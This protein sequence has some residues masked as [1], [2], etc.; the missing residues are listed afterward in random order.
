[1]NSGEKLNNNLKICGECSEWLELFKPCTSKALWGP[2]LIFVTMTLFSSSILYF[3]NI[4]LS[5]FN[6]KSYTILP[7]EKSMLAQPSAW[8]GINVKRFWFYL[9]F[10]VYHCYQLLIWQIYA[11]FTDVHN[12]MWRFNS[13]F[14]ISSQCFITILFEYFYWLTLYS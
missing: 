13:D 1:M 14:P 6:H 11:I 10:F 2:L 9:C 4:V 3:H 8:I 5:I 7:K 12:Y